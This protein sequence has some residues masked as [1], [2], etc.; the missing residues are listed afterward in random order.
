[1]GDVTLYISVTASSDYPRIVTSFVSRLKSI[2]S[3][4]PTRIPLPPL[5]K[6]AGVGICTKDQYVKLRSIIVSQQAQIILVS[7]LLVIRGY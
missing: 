6:F 5:L 2:S 4:T 3:P 1:M 7:L